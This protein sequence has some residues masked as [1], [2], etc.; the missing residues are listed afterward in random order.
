MTDDGF[1]FI[2]R[3]RKNAVVRVLDSFSL[4]SESSVLSDEMVVIGTAQNRTENVFRRLRLFDTK[5]T[6]L[7]Y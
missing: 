5:E 3:L 2:S 4:P 1:F 7:R 6:N